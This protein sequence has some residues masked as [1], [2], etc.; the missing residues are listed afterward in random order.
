VRKMLVLL[1][2]AVLAAACGPAPA[3][4]AAPTP[5]LS[6]PAPATAAAATATQPSSPLATPAA[7]AT[8]L[9]SPIGTPATAAPRL[10][11]EVGDD[12]A[13]RAA[14]AILTLRDHD[15]PAL[16]GLAH[17]L[18]GVTFAPYAFVRTPQQEG[19]EAAL[20]FTRDQLSGLWADPT[21]Y[22]WGVYDGSGEPIELTFQEYY[23]QF[24]YDVDFA[25]PEVIGYGQ[26]IGQGNS[27]NNIAE[28]WP[29]AVT[30]EYHFSGFDPQYDG[31]D[32]RSLRLVFEQADGI[33]YL[34]GVVHD[35]WTI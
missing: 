17:P 35:Q 25:Q 19:G 7:A 23:A 2:V 22:H 14:E 18:L 16:A 28:V 32:W 31:M 30:V 6:S 8:Q 24:V 5:A 1:F 11:G 15:L 26:S 9:P 4:T 20:T 10:V 21:V 27:I 29:A 34:V 3:P 33:W 12:L 13:A